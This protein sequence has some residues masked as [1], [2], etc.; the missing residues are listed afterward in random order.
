MRYGVLACLAL[1]VGWGLKWLT[2]DRQ[3]HGQFSGDWWADERLK[4]LR[5][6]AEYEGVSHRGKFNR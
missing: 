1:L 2:T 3:A 5:R 4:V 6:S